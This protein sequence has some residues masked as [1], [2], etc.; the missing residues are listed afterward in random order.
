[1]SPC[2]ASSGNF[3]ALNATKTCTGA[4]VSRAPTHIV[5][6]EKFLF[7][8]DARPLHP[9]SLSVGERCSRLQSTTLT[10][11][12]WTLA[13]LTPVRR[14]WGEKRSKKPFS[15]TRGLK[16]FSVLMIYLLFFGSTDSNYY[17]RF[18]WIFK[19]FDIFYQSS[20]IY[21]NNCKCCF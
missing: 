13:F 7:H 8:F 20:V 17:L 5:Q 15:S 12:F 19:D 3:W 9:L 2:D 11:F 10:V 4:K 14:Q 18:V 16:V 1:M 21:K 6:T